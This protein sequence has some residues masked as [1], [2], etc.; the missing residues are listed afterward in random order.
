MKVDSRRKNTAEVEMMQIT[1]SGS[2]NL[3]EAVKWPNKNGIKLQLW[4]I[5]M[6][7]VNIKP[8]FI[9]LLY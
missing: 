3:Q 9:S 6:Y 7:D 8:F 5:I 4:R 1:T 2:V